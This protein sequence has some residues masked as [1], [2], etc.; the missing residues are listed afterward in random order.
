M[1]DQLPPVA[2]APIYQESGGKNAKWLWILIVV[3]IL[4]AL[5]FAFF[6]G[7]GPFA[8]LK[9][10]KAS[11]TPSPSVTSEEVSSPS[12]EATAGATID[13]TKA[14]IRV[15]NGSGKTGAAS[16]TKDYLE[17][18]GY[19]VSSI[20]NAKTSDFTQTVIKFKD[21]FKNFQETLVADLSAKYS[22]KTDSTPLEASDSADIEI[23]IGSK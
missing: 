17:S 4:A 19:K 1:D 2:Q 11:P 12:P 3:I 16:T 5:G 21:A 9:G 22:V 18:K 20:G 6:K 15:L 8:G 7:I 23:T 14:K 13:K 10:A